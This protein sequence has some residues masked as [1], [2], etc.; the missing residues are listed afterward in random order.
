MPS[1]ENSAGSVG[2]IEP[3]GEFAVESQVLFSGKN[4]TFSREMKK[5]TIFLLLVA[6]LVWTP[7]QESAAVGSTLTGVVT[8]VIDG[9]SLLI[10]QGRNSYEVRLWGIDCPEY[11]QPYGGAARKMGTTLL[12]GKAV[13]VEAKSRDSYDRLV[14]VVYLGKINVNE[15]LVRQGAA[16]VYGRYCREAV[17]DEWRNLEE[18]AKSARLGLWGG[19]QPV[20]PWKWRRERVRGAGL[21]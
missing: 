17:C 12:R 4:L 13:T 16:W 10:R 2:K 19:K 14:G 5:I 20:P 3:A 6:F 15:E 9:D 18:R 1:L 21:K 11:D 7:G 8:K